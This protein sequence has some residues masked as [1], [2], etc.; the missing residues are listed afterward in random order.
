MT[1][2]RSCIALVVAGFLSHEARAT[3]GATLTLDA[4]GSH[5]RVANAPAL[6]PT[7]G[8]T[9]EA[10]IRPTS[11]DDF[12]TIVGKQFSTGYWLGLNGVGRIRYYAS[13][14]GTSRDGV[15]AVPLGQWTHVAVT[16]DGTTRRYYIDGA[17]D[18]SQSTPDAL[19]INVEPLGI[20]ADSNGAFDFEGNLAE[21]R[22]WSIARTQDEIRRDLA[23]QIDRDEPGLVGA[24]NLDGS[25]LELLGRFETERVGTARFTGPQAPPEP[26]YPLRIPRLPSGSS[27]NGE[28]GAGEY[29]PLRLPVWYDATGG[30]AWIW[31]GATQFTLHVCFD[32]LDRASHAGQSIASLQID[33][34]ASGGAF[35]QAVDDLRSVLEE[36]GSEILYTGVGSGGWTTAGTAGFASFFDAATNGA[37]EFTWD[38]ELTASRLLF[39][40]TAGYEF[41]L[42]L[43]QRDAIV[44]LDSFGWPL[45]A[46]F[47]TP[48][49]WETAYVD[50]T[51]L[52]RADSSNPTATLSIRPLGALVGGRRSTSFGARA[53]DDVDLATIEVYV[54]GDLEEI[55]DVDGSDDVAAACDLSLDVSLGMHYA[56]VVARDHRGRVGATP[57]QGFRIEAD[58]EAPLV[59]IAHAPLA[60]PV[61]ANARVTA[62][63]T[64]PTG[65]TRI[66][67]A[68]DTAPFTE[69]CSFGAGVTE[70][71]CEVDVPLTAARPWFHYRAS[72]E[73]VEDFV[74]RVGPR[75]AAASGAGPD[76]DG[77]ALPDALELSIC[78]SHLDPDT[79]RDGLPD[80]W[81]V[82]G[83]Q[84][85]GG[86][87]VD[88]PALGADACR[89]DVFLQYDYEVGARVEPGVIEDM[90]AA[91]RE[92][93]IALH[94]E[95]NERPR[96][97]EAAV[98]IIGSVDGAYQQDA[99]GDFWF[100]PERN[101]THIYAFSR[102]RV[103]RSGA[104]GRYFTF[105]IY[106][107]A[108]DCE[109]PL[110]EPD[111]N[112]CRAWRHDCVRES[113]AGQARRF[114]HEIGHSMGLGHGGQ[115]GFATP[116]RVGEYFYYGGIA[117]DSD[118]HKPNHVSVMNYGYNGGLY[119]VNPPPG[120]G[121][122]TGLDI[123]SKLTYASTSFGA[124]DEDALDERTT[125]AFATA[126]RAQSC[127]HAE[128]GAVPTARHTC[129]DGRETATGT[130]AEARVLILT[131][132]TNP[133]GRVVAGSAWTYPD[134]ADE[135]DG[136]D[137]DCDGVIEASVAENVNG[138]NA[139]YTLPGEVCNGEDDDA[140][141]Q[142]DEGCFWAGGQT[143]AS[144]NEWARIPRP[145]D[146]VELYLGDPANCYPQPAAYRAG[147]RS[148]DSMIDCRVRYAPAGADA[149]C[150]DRPVVETPY[151]PVDQ[152][153]ED[154]AP[155]LPGVE[156][157]DMDDNDGDRLVDEGCRDTDGD[158]VSDVIDGCPRTPN[159]DQLDAD[160]DFVGDACESPAPLGDLSVQDGPNGRVIGWKPPG[161]DVARVRVYRESLD[162]GS[163]T[164]LG[165]TGA[166]ASFTDTSVVDPDAPVRYRVVPLGPAGDEVIESTAAIPAPVPGAAALGATAL[167]TLRLLSRGR[168]PS[169][170]SE[171]PSAA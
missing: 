154:F 67:I 21:V 120:G 92:Q 73:D 22:I 17:L 164:Y 139:D 84:I 77:D 48:E 81:E 42:A 110:D 50:D 49:T 115:S 41:G 38:A 83:L 146:C 32:E 127:A 162:D 134:P 31:V 90:A 163:V 100:P 142:T 111:P 24:W 80:G 30:P 54:D 118:N 4:D 97:Q 5:L 18:L 117:W 150:P 75:I 91:M 130:D 151:T 102:H 123:V 36:D 20:G 14:S 26:F 37:Q 160:G 28:C 23:R 114:L 55:C 105:D 138:D 16:F 99:E 132:G 94:V 152:R 128:A 15:R 119:C 29:G 35:P 76:S 6:N 61:G 136:V 62:R 7:G 96:W 12:P 171:G 52:P 13:G 153:E 108:D 86:A 33:R 159:A 45:G 161:G 170:T 98:S 79:D 147:M 145:P 74:S 66:E 19:P 82:R 71:V 11:F 68:L 56:Y 122:R 72:A 63:A 106:V 157:C 166:S 109:C 25:E 64:D 116:Q 107:G 10:W 60:P 103:G 8:I 131:D 88:L 95:E 65:V 44:P 104:W 89:K 112:D 57:A 158:G 87:L 47:A 140:N 156:F 135:P 148:H 58:G 40:A 69:T 27:P 2:W 129:F 78:T 9:I 70:A 93:G 59:T 167:A 133:L 143:L 169:T 165:E 121:A 101:W 34:N 53:A 168:S 124:L 125:S 3:T 1:R 149:T 155:E 141:G 46:A 85:P 113:R 43:L 39:P 137:F 144:T 126:L 51:N